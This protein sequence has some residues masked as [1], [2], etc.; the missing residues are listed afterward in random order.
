MD[1]ISGTLALIKNPRQEKM[2]RMRIASIQRCVVWCQKHELP[3]N[4][5][6]RH[7]NMFLSA[8]NK[9]SRAPKKK[10]SEQATEQEESAVTEA[11]VREDAANGEA[12]GGES[13]DA[14]FGR[15][16]VVVPN[17]SCDAI[18]TDTDEQR[19]VRDIC[20]Q[21]VNTIVDDAQ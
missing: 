14:S 9:V 18:H 1:N 16:L 19:H 5:D 4:R 15:D 3:Y 13:E 21:M 7:F 17:V 11:G 10:Y 2:E 8:K 6:V 12:A 20:E